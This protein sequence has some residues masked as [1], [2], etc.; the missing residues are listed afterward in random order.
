MN[1]LLEEI[2]QRLDVYTASFPST[3][4]QDAE[5]LLERDATR[6]VSLKAQ[7]AP[8]IFDQSEIYMGYAVP[9]PFL[10]PACGEEFRLDSLLFHAFKGRPSNNVA[11]SPFLF[12]SFV[13][14]LFLYTFP[15]TLS[16]VC[17]VVLYLSLYEDSYER[18]FCPS[19]EKKLRF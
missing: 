19:S 10:H 15:F 9:S 7:G 12:F 8:I 4:A 13:F 1:I 14:R 3:V 6:A 11:L 2:W 16:L 17:F 18:I 5:K